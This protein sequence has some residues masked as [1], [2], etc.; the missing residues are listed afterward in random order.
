MV[1]YR[2]GRPS[3]SFSYAIL[4]VHHLSIELTVESN[5]SSDLEMKLH[6]SV[7]H[8]SKQFFKS[9]SLIFIKLKIKTKHF[10]LINSYHF[11]FEFNFFL[12]FILTFFFI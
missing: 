9:V 7:I 10:F 12:K 2:T 3:G 8:K 4:T 1:R 11:K 5:G 6:Q